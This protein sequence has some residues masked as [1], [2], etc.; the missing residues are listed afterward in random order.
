MKRFFLGLCFL[1]AMFS[2]SANQLSDSAKIYLLT[3]QPGTEVYATFGHSALYVEDK[4]QGIDAVFNY[5]IFDFDEESFLYKFIK[6]ETYYVLGV[7]DFESFKY[8]YAR[9]QCGISA[10]ELN[11]TH[12]EKE[13]L[14][15]ALVENAQ[16]ENRRYLYNFFY[17]NCATRIRDIVEKNVEGKITFPISRLSDRAIT[18]R[19]LIAEFTGRNSWLKFGIDILIG[20]PADK[21]GVSDYKKMFLPYYLRDFYEMATVEQKSLTLPKTQIIPAFP[22]EN[23]ACNFPLITMFGILLIAILISIYEIRKKCQ[24]IWF[25]FILFFVAGLI[26]IVVTFVEFFSIHPAVFPNFNILWLHPLQLV[27]AILLLI[28][29]VRG[30]LRFYH[31]FNL[32]MIVF[33]AVLGL[34]VQA[35]NPAFFPLLGAMAIRNIRYIVWKKS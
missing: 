23:P 8:G 26:G 19:E 2:V 22:R 30:K 7:N 31:Y 10:Q 15:D 14:F 6:G 27:F 5:G 32:A 4:T 28:K 33:A 1:A 35:F 17:D 21:K 25:D 9:R 13:R 3:C 18:Y 24:T 34:T 16:F 11:L 12:D 29:P 20:A